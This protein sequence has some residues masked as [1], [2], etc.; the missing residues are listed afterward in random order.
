MKTSIPFNTDL[1]NYCYNNEKMFIHYLHPV[2]NYFYTNQIKNKTIRSLK[3]GSDNFL[4]AY[5]FEE[6]K[7]YFKKYHY[8]RKIGILSDNERDLSCT[9]RF[10]GESIRNQIANSRQIVLE[11]T[12][13]CN[14]KCKYCGYGEFYDFYEERKGIN[15][16]FEKAKILLLYFIDLWNSNRNTSYKKNIYIS[17]YGGEPLLNFSLVEKV[18]AFL[19]AQHLQNVRFTYSM[20]TNGVLL[21]KYLDFLV[22]H[23]FK[24]LISLDGDKENNSYRVFKNGENS[25]DVVYNNSLYIKNNFKDYFIKHVNFNAT[26]QNRNNVSDI[27]NFFVKE[28]G[29]KVQI[30]ELTTM[31]I[32]KERKEEFYNT[33]NNFS[34]SLS[35]SED[36]EH[37]EKV[38]FS[39]LPTIKN[40]TNFL[41]QHLNN[42][43]KNHRNF[44][45]ERSLTNFVP[46]GTC[47][48]FGRKV[49]LTAS[50]K[51]LF[52]E[53]I[54]HEYSSANVNSNVNIDY[55][56]IAINVNSYY[57][58]LNKQCNSCYNSRN[59]FQCIYLLDNLKEKPVCRGFTNEER[60]K[61]MLSRS[62]HTFEMRPQLYEKIMK[63]VTLF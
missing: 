49:F 16:D 6:I 54:P 19:N 11:V 44:Y 59:C 37:I 13:M 41:H 5:S 51:I 30:G 48:P 39:H 2:V 12:D 15:M 10:S 53:R 34:E 9:G 56:L 29:K 47:K 18:V 45:S 20:T 26:L 3:I 25:Y 36:Y 24:L 57:D 21:K 8:F 33:Y 28:F 52:C 46:T 42:V 35:Q 40:L 32:L 7:Y 14:L 4:S 60:Y 63:K 50:G 22:K 55:D 43:Y 1:Y 62:V 38:L 23:Q 27:S 17:F 58:S 61:E 31:G